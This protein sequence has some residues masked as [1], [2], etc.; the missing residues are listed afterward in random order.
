M[1]CIGK[2]TLR[3]VPCLRAQHN[4]CFSF[5][6]NFKKLENRK[7]Q[8][9]VLCQVVTDP[10]C[11]L[12]V[13]HLIGHETINIPEIFSGVYGFMGKDCKGLFQANLYHSPEFMNHIKPPLVII[14]FRDPI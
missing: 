12:V 14:K 10:C 8:L 13:S 7:S 5:N 2:G 9:V 6:Q 1:H 3:V 11:A 4:G